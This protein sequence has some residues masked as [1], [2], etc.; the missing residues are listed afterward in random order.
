MGQGVDL[1]MAVSSD[2]GAKTPAVEAESSSAALHRDLLRVVLPYV[3]IAGLWIYG[4]DTLLGWLVRDPARM[5]VLATYK[6][7]L[8]VAV[9]GAM[10]WWMLHRLLTRLYAA[11]NNARRMQ[12]LYAALSSINRSNTLAQS[13]EELYRQACQALVRIAGLKMAW[14]GLEDP[15]TRRIRSVVQEGDDHGYLK[16]I[17]VFSDLRPEGMGPVGKAFREC[18]PFVLNDFL[19]DEASQPWHKAAAQ[20][21]FLAA[22]ALPLVNNGRVCGILAAYAGEIGFF[23]EQEI[24]LLNQV[25][26][27][28]SE[29]LKLFE[30]EQRRQQMEAE[31]REKEALLSHMSAVAQVGGWAFDPATGAG[32]WTEEIARIH[33]LDPQIRPSVELGVSFYTEESRTKILAAVKAAREQGIPYDLE[34]ELVTPKNNRKW[35][36]TIGN[37]IME[38][39][40]VVRV[41]GA[42]QDITERRKAEEK[43]QQLNA[44]L[45]QRVRDRTAQLEALNKELEAFSYSVSHDLRA[46]VRAMDGFA[47]ML[48]DHASKQLDAEGQRMLG[49]IRG[50]AARMGK[51]IDDLLAFSR[52]SRRPMQSA[53]VDLNAL[54]RAAFQECAAQPGTRPALFNLAPLEPVQGDADMLRQAL[55]N[56]FSNALKYTRH[57]PQPVVEMGCR[58]EGAEVAYWVKDNGVGFDMRY[59]HK[60]FGVFQR[61]H[62]EEEFEGTDV[63]LALV[64]RIIQRHHGRVWAE[65][66]LHEGATFYFSLPQPQN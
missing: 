60:L 52:L 49:V 30:N 57:A 65:S 66:R 4:S 18:K 40:R 15:I 25:A 36:R 5:T 59:V 16:Q 61:L 64:Q 29:A 55:I 41:L 45:E 33:D 44:E 24:E 21:G 56:L 37:P 22:A 47:R 11:R 20:H 53:R 12:G 51:L 23:Q 2:T 58:R 8:F 6:G 14:I 3:L 27:D 26:G 34:L 42:L 43:I 38:D 54:A 13:P 63:G 19:H 28:I 7:W 32:T 17:E 35:V 62:T 50:E 9:T 1:K 46:P 31:L 10:L 39:G 48:E